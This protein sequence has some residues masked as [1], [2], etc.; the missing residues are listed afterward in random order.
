MPFDDDSFDCVVDTFS[1]CVFPDPAAALREVAR[2]L[3]P[4]GSALLLEHCRSPVTPLAWYQVHTQV[5]RNAN[6][7][8]HVSSLSC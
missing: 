4:G 1:L 8:F 5:C 6:I 7:T 3:R 2:V